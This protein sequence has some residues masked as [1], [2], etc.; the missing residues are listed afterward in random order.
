MKILLCFALVGFFTY[1]LFSSETILFSNSTPVIRCECREAS[2][3]YSTTHTYK[4]AAFLGHWSSQIASY[5]SLEDGIPVIR[6]PISFEVDGLTSV[7]HFLSLNKG[8]GYRQRKYSYYYSCVIWEDEEG[9]HETRHWMP[10]HDDEYADCT[11][12]IF[13]EKNP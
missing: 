9:L 12:H 6:I 3:T 13:E 7:S 2:K 1:P 4:S 5:W 8:N 11:N 10:R